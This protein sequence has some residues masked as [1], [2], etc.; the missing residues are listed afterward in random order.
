MHNNI[1]KIREY[2]FDC[3]P[4]LDDGS[5]NPGSWG[6]FLNT[7]IEFYDCTLDNGRT[8]CIAPSFTIGSI[9]YINKAELIV[10]DMLRVLESSCAA[11]DVNYEPPYVNFVAY[12]EAHK[13]SAT[14]WDGPILWGLPQLEAKLSIDQSF[15][16]NHNQDTV[17]MVLQSM[18]G[19]IDTMHEI[20]GGN[21]KL[22]NT[23]MIVYGDMFSPEF[24][25]SM[26]YTFPG[27]LHHSITGLP[28]RVSAMGRQNDIIFMPWHYPDIYYKDFY[29]NTGKRT[30]NTIADLNWFTS[31]GCKVIPGRTICEGNTLTNI[32]SFLREMRKTMNAIQ[33]SSN[34]SNIIGITSFH[35][36]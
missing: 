35:F 30:F 22:K 5:H 31:V 14:I 13:N 17:G 16:D 15:L 29:F 34:P 27:K 8:P 23:K 10:S 21:G 4:L 11:I 28:S 25:N 1:K 7:G 9:T 3:I 32:P 33:S 36:L 24:E 18:I 12:S 2:D 6:V 19:R 20:N 26:Q